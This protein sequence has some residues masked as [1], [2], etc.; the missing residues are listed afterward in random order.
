MKIITGEHRSIKIRPGDT[1]ILSSSVIP[2][3]ERSVQAV[4]DD[5]AR[6]GAIIFHSNIVDIHSSGHAAKE[7]LQLAMKLI[8]PKFLIPVHGYYYK[9]FI[10]AQNAVEAGIPKQ[11]IILMDNGQVA[12]I[13]KT[14]IRITEQTVPAFYVMVDGLGVGDVEEVVIRD[15]RALAAEGMVVIIITVDREKG[16]LLKSPDIIS[17]GFI[18]LKEN[19]EVLEGI[20]KRLRVLIGRLPMHQPIDPDYLKTLVRDQIGQF[21]YN[22]TRRR[23]MIL[24]VIIEI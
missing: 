11:N 7:D 22:E 24:P 13:T 9:R 20:R 6:Q 17:R 3:N 23:P 16:K 5:L 1:V 4:K 12:E 18:Y 14:S 2:G 15:R 19:Q 8:N 10:N 21:L